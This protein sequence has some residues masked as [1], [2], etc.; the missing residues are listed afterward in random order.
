MRAGSS[1]ASMLVLRSGIKKGPSTAA[2]AA[3]VRT[4]FDA[5]RPSKGA[6]PLMLRG[7]A[8]TDGLSCEGRNKCPGVGPG[9]YMQP[10]CLTGDAV[11]ATGLHAPTE[12]G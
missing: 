11:Q 4:F 3:G 5:F 2:A 10:S 7:P 12:G 8:C 9:V 1:R 6:A